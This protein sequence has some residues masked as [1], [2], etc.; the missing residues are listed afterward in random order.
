MYD[1]PSHGLPGHDRGNDLS[2]QVMTTVATAPDNRDDS[3]S[4]AVNKASHTMTLTEA[5]AEF[6]NAGLP[7]SERTTSRYCARGKIDCLK[8]DP[9]TGEET[10]GKHFTYVVNPG[11]LAKQFARMHEKRELENRRLDMSRQGASPVST[12]P[13]MSSDD[14][15]RHDMSE[16]VQALNKDFIE[17]TQLGTVDTVAEPVAAA[18][19]DLEK[20]LKEAQQQISDLEKQLIDTEIEKRAAFSV[21]DLV[22]KQSSELADKFGDTKYQ[23]GAAEAQLQALEAPKNHG[24]ETHSEHRE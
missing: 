7:I 5:H 8:I 9:E 14:M 24:S 10:D 6:A 17:A 15:S 1:N 18:Q 13:D 3:N 2:G 20:K 21:R 4:S 23:L 19:E 16:P 22:V 11:S 12:S